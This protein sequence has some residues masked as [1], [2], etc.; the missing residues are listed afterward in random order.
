VKIVIW[1]GDHPKPWVFETGTDRR[2]FCGD[3]NLQNVSELEAV[4]F[5]TSEDTT[6]ENIK[7]VK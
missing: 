6:I 3:G 7:K 1:I 5:R 4:E 2:Y